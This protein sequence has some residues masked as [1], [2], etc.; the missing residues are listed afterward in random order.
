[1]EARIGT[2]PNTKW[3]MKEVWNLKELEQGGSFGWAERGFP[4]YVS[5][6][7]DRLGRLAVWKNV[8]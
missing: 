4:E 3:E 6:R 7:A 8:L 1:M 2:L 5:Y